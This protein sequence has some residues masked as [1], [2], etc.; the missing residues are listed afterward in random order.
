[1]N[2]T[3]RTA[4]EW[5]R[6][7][8]A[9]RRFVHVPSGQAGNLVGHCRNVGILFLRYEHVGAVS[10]PVFERFPKAELVPETEVAR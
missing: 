4:K 9:R 3:P 5:T 8:Q 6:D 7:A 2:A 1:M 10:L